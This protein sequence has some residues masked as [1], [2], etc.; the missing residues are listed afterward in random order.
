M[1]VKKV[2]ILMFFIIILIGYFL[3]SVIAEEGKENENLVFQYNDKEYDID[4]NS[5]FKEHNFN[6]EDYPYYLIKNDDYNEK[7]VC[8]YFSKT[9]MKVR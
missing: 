7:N 3:D 8:I 1:K 6:L 5:I 4:I 9:R 2:F